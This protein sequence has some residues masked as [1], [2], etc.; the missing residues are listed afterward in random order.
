MHGIQPQPFLSHR[1]FDHALAGGRPSFPGCTASLTRSS[2]KRI[3]APEAVF[4]RCHARCTP[5]LTNAPRESRTVPPVGGGN[6]RR[7]GQSQAVG[8]GQRV[9]GTSW[10]RRGRIALSEL[11]AGSNLGDREKQDPIPQHLRRLWQIVF[12]RSAGNHLEATSTTGSGSGRTLP[13]RHL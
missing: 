10:G 5:H 1:P 3:T 11:L 6:N 13:D 4:S 2:H 9:R 7:R 8:F 12:D